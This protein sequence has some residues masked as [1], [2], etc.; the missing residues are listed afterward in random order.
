MHNVTIDGFRHGI[1]AGISSL[2]HLP[3]DCHLE[4]ADAELLLNSNTYIEPTL[5]VGYFMSYSIKG[6][7]YSGHP[8]LKRLDRFRDQNYR[9]MVAETW[10]PEL[11]PTRLAMNDGLKKGELKVYGIIDI[12]EPFRY[13]ARLIPTGGQNLRLLIRNGAAS[14]IGCGNDAGPTNCS[15]ADIRYELLTLDFILNNVDKGTFTPADLLR[16]ATIQSARSM[17]VDALF[18]SIKTGKVADLVVLDGDPLQDFHLVGQPVRALFMD[19][20]LLINR[21]G[22]EAAAP[23][24]VDHA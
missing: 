16:T 20:N 14:R 12:S 19:G 9:P 15:A 23:V 7:P 3:L 21:C 11:L 13:Y 4:E 8:E 10:L 6:S 24:S 1:Q 17:G 22:L 18:G 5:T 2:A